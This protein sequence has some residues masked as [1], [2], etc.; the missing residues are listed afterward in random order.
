MLVLCYASR[1]FLISKCG[2]YTVAHAESI[3]NRNITFIMSNIANLINERIN[4]GTVSERNNDGSI[5]NQSLN[6]DI[7][8][9]LLNDKK[10]IHFVLHLQRRILYV[11][12]H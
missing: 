8:I 1:I 7:D 3:E 2:N 12:N 5:F 4:G 6:F 11:C 10:K 9:T